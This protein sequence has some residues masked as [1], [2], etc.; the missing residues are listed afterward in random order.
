MAFLSHGKAS[1]P[2]S[3]PHF[4]WE[5]C[6]SIQN[7][8][9]NLASWENRPGDFN[10]HLFLFCLVAEKLNK[11]KSNKLTFSCAGLR[12]LSTLPNWTWIS[13]CISV[14]DLG[15]VGF[16]FLWTQINKVRF[17][18]CLIFFSI[19]LY[20]TNRV[21]VPTDFSHYNLN[22]MFLMG[23]RPFVSCFFLDKSVL[24]CC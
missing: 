14:E 23:I 17:F 21:K 11:C 2:N 1:D 16:Q 13:F 19:S 20:V 9:W 7:Q 4:G 22:G 5:N 10:S 12:N 6:S 15:L 3:E 18:F 8:C 24:G